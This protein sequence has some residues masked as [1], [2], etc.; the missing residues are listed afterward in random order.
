MPYSQAY[1]GTENGCNGWYE[2]G[3]YKAV[4]KVNS[5]IL[6]PTAIF[7][8]KFILKWKAQIPMAYSPKHCIVFPFP[9]PE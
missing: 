7:L 8:F 4:I 1:G 2:N 3:I 5:R 9:P 6:F